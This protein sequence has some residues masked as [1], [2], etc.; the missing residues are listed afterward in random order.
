MKIVQSFWTAS[1]DPTNRLYIGSKVAR[2]KYLGN[3]TKWRSRAVS[4]VEWQNSKNR[5]EIRGSR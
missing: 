2:V 4:L 1:K 3:K 5:K